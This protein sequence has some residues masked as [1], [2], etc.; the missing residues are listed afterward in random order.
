M[1]YLPATHRRF[2]QLWHAEGQGAHEVVPGSPVPVPHLHRQPA[3]LICSLQLAGITHRHMY[4]VNDNDYITH[5]TQMW[6]GP[7]TV[8]RGTP[9]LTMWKT[10]SRWGWGWRGWSWSSSWSHSWGLGWAWAWRKGQTSR[11]DPWGSDFDLRPLM[12][13]QHR[14]KGWFLTNTLY[15]GIGDITAFSVDYFEKS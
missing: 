7:N 6:K 1:L 15:S 2:D 8:P 13:K 10:H 14:G 3:V 11:W 12:E 4:R 5:N 9:Q